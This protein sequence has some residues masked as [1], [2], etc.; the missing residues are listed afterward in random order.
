MAPGA[1]APDVPHH[2][3]KTAKVPLSP[4]YREWQHQRGAKVCRAGCLVRLREGLQGDAPIVPHYPGEEARAGGWV[5][6]SLIPISPT[7]PEC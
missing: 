5:T 7:I 4:T 1:L 2:W 6:A 3:R